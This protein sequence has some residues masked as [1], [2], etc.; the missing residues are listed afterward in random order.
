M[1][2]TIDW[3][4]LMVGWHVGFP[5]ASLGALVDRDDYLL[6]KLISHGVVSGSG[7]IVDWPEGTIWAPLDADI[8]W[9]G[10]LPALRGCADRHGLAAECTRLFEA[11][12][13]DADGEYPEVAAFHRILRDLSEAGR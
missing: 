12:G 8:D 11:A 6:N 4:G 9:T 1:I 5:F 3:R 13:L 2:G 7:A 10:F